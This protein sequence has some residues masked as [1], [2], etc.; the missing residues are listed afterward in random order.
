MTVESTAAFMRLAAHQLAH[1][2]EHDYTELSDTQRCDL[3]LLPCELLKWADN[4]DPGGGVVA[5][6]VHVL[7]VAQVIRFPTRIPVEARR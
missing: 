5:A 4:I 1:A 2:I 7:P 6:P 3:R